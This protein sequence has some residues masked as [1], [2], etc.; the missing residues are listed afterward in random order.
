MIRNQSASIYD[1]IKNASYYGPVHIHSTTG[2]PADPALNGVHLVWNDGSKPSE[3]SG[4]RGVGWHSD[5]TY[6]ENCMGFT[7][8]KVVNA[9]STGGDT[10]WSNAQALLST[11]S[12]GFIAY[13][14]GLKALHSSDHQKQRAINNGTYIR[15]PQTDYI[16]PVVRVH[17]V[18]GIK[19]LYVNPSYTRRIVGI[20]E[21]ESDAI[22]NVIYRR[23][24]ACP[25]MQVR[26]NWEKDTVVMW[27]NRLTWH[28]AIGDYFPERRHGLRA[29]PRAEIPISVEKYEKE[30]GKKAKDWYNERMKGFGIDVSG[31]RLGAGQQK[32]NGAAPLKAGD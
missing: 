8:L 1:L 27:D 20:P 10:I 17:P 24:E 13:L 31:E 16:H 3:W 23:I 2:V 6:E 11:F 18:T 12:P 9:P 32:V 28:T 22:L 5:Q 15:R 7:A 19:G 25:D 26:V 29:T 21:H 4:N 14:E 30:T